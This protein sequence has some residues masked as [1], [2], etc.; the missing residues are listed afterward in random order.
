MKRWEPAHVQ[1]AV[2]ANRVSRRLLDLANVNMVRQAHP[3]LGRILIDLAGEL[4]RGFR[5]D[6]RISSRE[7]RAA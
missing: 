3:A 2:A 7:G 4:R 1:L 6:R 5:P